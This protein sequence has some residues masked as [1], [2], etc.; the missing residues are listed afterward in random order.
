M[1][2]FFALSPR[3]CSLIFTALWIRSTRTDN[4][5]LSLASSEG[6]RSNLPCGTVE[7][8][9][10]PLER[11]S[12]WQ[13]CLW[14]WKQV[15][16]GRCDGSCFC[17][18]CPPWD[19]PWNKFLHECNL[20]P[21][22]QASFSFHYMLNKIMSSNIYLFNIQYMENIFNK[23]W[24]RFLERANLPFQSESTLVMAALLATCHWIFWCCLHTVENPKFLILV[25]SLISREKCTLSQ[26]AARKLNFQDT[27]R[28]V[29]ALTMGREAYGAW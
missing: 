7:S 5:L 24:I 18:D 16:D 19:F 13:S 3:V 21:C 10:S 23:V 22:T 27:E 2:L 9:L 8:F 17:K 20:L 29:K 6:Y 25:C 1:H 4:W 12:S 14:G 26:M 15:A 11:L 28:K